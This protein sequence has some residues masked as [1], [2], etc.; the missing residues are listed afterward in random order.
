[1]AEE[2]NKKILFDNIAFLVKEQGKKIGEVETAAG[3]SP[4]YISRSS[5]DGGAKPGIDFIVNIAEELG[6]SIDT[7]LKFDLTAL[8]PTEQ[9]LISFLDRL[10]SQTAKGELDWKRE[11]AGM[12][13]RLEADPYEGTGHPLFFRQTF[14][15]PTDCEYPQE[16]TR[17]VFDSNSFDCNT[18]INGDCFILH[19]KNDTA[20]YVMNISKAVSKKSDPASQAIELWLVPERSSNQFLCSTLSNAVLAPVIVKVYD[21]IIEYYKHPQ[22]SSDIRTVIDAFMKGDLGQFDDDDGQLPF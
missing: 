11:S 19:M 7:L 22:I 17:V 4:G 15:E 10:D 8:S 20:L 2:F 14:M 3:V 5:K 1:M 13:N 12:L 18:Y 6:V 9:Y 21:A 16:V